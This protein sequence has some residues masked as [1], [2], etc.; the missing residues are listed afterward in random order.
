MKYVMN[1]VTFTMIEPRADQ[2]FSRDRGG[3]S[4]ILSVLFFRPNKLIFL[5]LT[6]YYEDP[7][8]TNNFAPQAN[9]RNK[10][11]KNAVLSIFFGKF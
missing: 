1:I 9:F 7:I 10:R 4:K 11:V 3:F 8:W 6:E 5:A 2:G